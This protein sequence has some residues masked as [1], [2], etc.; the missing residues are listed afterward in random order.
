MELIS[1]QG[2]TNFFEKRVGEYQKAGVYINWIT[3]GCRW[4]ASVKPFVEF[5][6]YV[7]C[8]WSAI[9]RA[10]KKM[11]ENNKQSSWHV[12]R[13][14]TR[15]PHVI[16]PHGPFLRLHLRLKLSQRGSSAHII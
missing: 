3:S 8:I 14:E 6:S 1:L 12:W 13:E 15:C 11:S 9:A 2:K 7:I 5:D 16:F 4:Q 10:A